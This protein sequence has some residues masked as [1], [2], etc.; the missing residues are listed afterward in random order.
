LQDLKLLLLHEAKR[1][2]H[3]DADAF[4]LCVLSHGARGKV[5]GVDGAAVEVDKHIIQLFNGTVCP[6]LI[7]KPKIIIIQACQGGK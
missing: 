7:N 3:A 4:V 6:T 5:Y 2:A 1:P